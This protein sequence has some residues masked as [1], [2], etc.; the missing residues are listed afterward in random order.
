MGQ[1]G[2]AQLVARYVRDVEAGSSSL[3]TP[4]STHPPLSNPSVSSSSSVSDSVFVDL[5][6]IRDLF[7]VHVLCSTRAPAAPDVELRCSIPAVGN[8]RRPTATVGN[9]AERV[10]FE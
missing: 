10:N 5:A 9:P 1:R 2:V 4:T 3:P 6:S 8:R 7:S